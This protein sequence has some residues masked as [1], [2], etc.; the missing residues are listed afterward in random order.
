MRD[1][2]KI[3]LKIKFN[4]KSMQVTIFI[5]AMKLISLINIYAIS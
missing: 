4:S 2:S 1:F 5:E 3:D